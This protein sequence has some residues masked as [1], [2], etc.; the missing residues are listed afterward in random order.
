MQPQGDVNS[1]IPRNSATKGLAALS[2][3]SV[4]VPVC[5]IV[6]SVDENDAV[7]D[8]EGRVQQEHH[9]AVAKARA[10]ARRYEGKVAA[11]KKRGS[12]DA[13]APVF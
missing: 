6:P 3:T 11:E 7:G 4:G 8:F 2:R 1:W 5:W 10:N 13:G 12:R 9:G